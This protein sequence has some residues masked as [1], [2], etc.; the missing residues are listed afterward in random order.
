MFHVSLVLSY[1]QNL[2]SKIENFNVYLRLY[3]MY[4]TKYGVTIKK[5]LVL[6][7]DYWRS[8]NKELLG[9]GVE[10]GFS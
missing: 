10:L 9:L 8:R 4:G 1:S 6:Q 3:H 2:K 5:F 7:F